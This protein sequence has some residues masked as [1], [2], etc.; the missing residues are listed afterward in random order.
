M[1]RKTILIGIGIVLILFISAITALYLHFKPLLEDEEM[2]DVVSNLMGTCIGKGCHSTGSSS[3]SGFGSVDCRGYQFFYICLSDAEKYCRYFKPFESREKCVCEIKSTT[4]SKDSF[5]KFCPKNK[6]C[7]SNS[8]EYEFGCSGDMEKTC[9]ETE[10]VF[11]EKNACKGRE[12]H[13]LSYGLIRNE[14]ECSKSWLYI[15]IY[16]DDDQKYN[17]FNRYQNI[18]NLLCA[19]CNSS[20]CNQGSICEYSNITT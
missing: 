5:K 9:R 16:A 8:F 15:Y 6:V 2:K 19:N 7:Y 17:I 12:L 14:A 10:K 11:T 13:F 4:E 1:K 18:C 20:I 3:T